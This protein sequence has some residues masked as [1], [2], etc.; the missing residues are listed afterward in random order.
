[1]VNLLFDTKDM[2]EKFV[3]ES[4]EHLEEFAQYLETNLKIN[5]L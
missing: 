3:S 2:N 4:N 1:M 5:N